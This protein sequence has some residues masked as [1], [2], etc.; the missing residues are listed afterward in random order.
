MKCSFFE[1]G[2]GLTDL[3][4]PVYTS[5]YMDNLASMTLDCDGNLVPFDEL[6]DGEDD[7]AVYRICGPLTDL[8]EKSLAPDGSW[9]QETTYRVP[10]VGSYEEM[11]QQ[12]LNYY[13]EK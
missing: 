8:A 4:N 9:K 12:Y 2:S 11:L 1:L 13:F 5:Y 10:D 3:E 6:G 7:S